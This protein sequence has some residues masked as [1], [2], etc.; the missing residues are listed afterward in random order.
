M[1]HRSTSYGPKSFI[2]SVNIA[3]NKP[4]IV[5]TI[6]GNHSIIISVDERPLENDKN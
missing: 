3:E 4:K 2:L 6:V 1:G 5:I